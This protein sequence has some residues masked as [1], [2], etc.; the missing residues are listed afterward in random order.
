MQRRAKLLLLAWTTLLGSCSRESTVS[1]E[2]AEGDAGAP[3]VAFRSRLE[4][5]VKGA[6]TQVRTFDIDADGLPEL[7]ATTRGVVGSGGPRGHLYLWSEGP[8]EPPTGRVQGEAARE[9]HHTR[10]T[11]GP[12]RRQSTTRTERRLRTRLFKRPPAGL[13]FRRRHPV[14][15]ASVDLHRAAAFRYPKPVTKTCT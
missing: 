7:A 2:Q 1:T 9:R 3:G 15:P 11:A 12:E 4:I 5:P 14:D 13:K 6:P 10:Q 8:D